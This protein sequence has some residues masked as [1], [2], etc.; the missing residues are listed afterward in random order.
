MYIY[1]ISALENFERDQL[2][3]NDERKVVGTN[4]CVAGKHRHLEVY[5]Q[6]VER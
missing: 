4:L 6:A 1:V 3:K 2:N 5:R